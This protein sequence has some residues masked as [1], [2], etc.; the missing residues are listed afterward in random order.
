MS[1]NFW[2]QKL[3]LFRKFFGGAKAFCCGI[4]K[5]M[6]K[7]MRKSIVFAYFF[8][9]EFLINMKEKDKNFI[10]IMRGRSKKSLVIFLSV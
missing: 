8:N 1:V 9:S 7:F 4:R 10:K 5:I 3:K 2:I 6:I